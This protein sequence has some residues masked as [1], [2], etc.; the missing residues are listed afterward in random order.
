[1][2][3]SWFLIN[4][5]TP[6]Q[7]ILHYTTPSYTVLHCTTLHHTTLYYTTLKCTIVHHTTPH[8]TTLCTI[9]PYHTTPH[10]ITPHHTR[11]HHTTP[12]SVTSHY[13]CLSLT[14]LFQPGP[15][16]W[17]WQQDLPQWLLPQGK[18]GMAVTDI[19]DF[20]WWQHWVWRISE[21]VSTDSNGCDW[22]LILSI[23]T[24]MVV[25][26]LKNCP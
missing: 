18:R 15:S 13:T 1:M 24:G 23:V 6:H 21:T 2:S 19:W 20:Q 16:V 10:H 8:H 25:I 3:F 5:T 4:C 17:H 11:L 26:Y 9:T 12:H 7:T 22:P 14:P